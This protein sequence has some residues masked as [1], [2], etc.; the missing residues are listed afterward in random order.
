MRSE[1]ELSHSLLNHFLS[2][3]S[4]SNQLLSVIVKLT[5]SGSV[6]GLALTLRQLFGPP[7]FQLASH[8]AQLP[9]SGRSWAAHDHG[10]LPMTP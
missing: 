8:P 7:L 2:K 6:G 4:I 3:Y 5:Y 10:C 9:P 1:Q